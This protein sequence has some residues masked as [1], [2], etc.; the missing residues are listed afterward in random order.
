MPLDAQGLEITTRAQ[1][2]ERSCDTQELLSYQVQQATA[3][4]KG[5]DCSRVAST[6]GT[7]STDRHRFAKSITAP[8][9]EA[10]I[11]HRRGGRC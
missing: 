1:I 8:Y 6:T 4:R 10:Q 2:T 11:T 5:A 3:P 7:A 9:D